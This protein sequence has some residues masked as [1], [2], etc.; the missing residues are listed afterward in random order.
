MDLTLLLAIILIAILMILT[1]IL[2][3]QFMIATFI[4]SQTKYKKFDGT[5]DER[6]KNMSENF[7]RLG[8]SFQESEEAAKK[9]NKA[10]K[11]CRDLDKEEEEEDEG[12][13]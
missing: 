1:T 11:R 6:M 5:L 13:D 9:M 10:F 4:K 7:I 8:Q 3:Y 12:K 2:V